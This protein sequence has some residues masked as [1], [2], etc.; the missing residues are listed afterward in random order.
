LCIDFFS[1]CLTIAQS[2]FV[3][4]EALSLSLSLSLHSDHSFMDTSI[5]FCMFSS[6]SVSLLAL[7]QRVPGESQIDGAQGAAL[8]R[9]CRR[10]ERGRRRGQHIVQ[11]AHWWSAPDDI[12]GR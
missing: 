1:R 4:L 11:C 9:N 7:L 3:L 5:Y 12:D 10:I 2:H 8:C 6:P